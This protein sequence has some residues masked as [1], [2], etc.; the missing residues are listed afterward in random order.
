MVVYYNKHMFDEAGLEYPQ[1]GWTWDQFR[2]TAEKL[3]RMVFTDFVSH[4][5]T[6]SL[7]RGGQPTMQH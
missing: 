3:P 5:L 1:D 7:H 4:V 6:F 2:E